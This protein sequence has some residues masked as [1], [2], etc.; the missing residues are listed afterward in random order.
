MS[1]EPL[2]PR[3][4]HTSPLQAA[5]SAFLLDRQAACCTPNTP[6]HYRY[7]SA[8]RR[9]AVASRCGGAVEAGTARARRRCSTTPHACAPYA[10]SAAGSDETISPE[11]I[12]TARVP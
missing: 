1:A 6:E 2:T 4:L 8:D 10:R 9:V 11:A 5:L 3:A 12:R 7:T